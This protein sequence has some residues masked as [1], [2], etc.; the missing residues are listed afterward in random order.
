MKVFC[1]A[2]ILWMTFAVGL[3]ADDAPVVTVI[4]IDAMP[5]FTQDAATLLDQFKADSMKL[6]A[7]A[8][9]FQVLQEIG[10]TNH[11]TLV[12]TWSDSKTYEAH[13][14]AAHTRA[15]RD[16]MQP[17]LGSPFDERTHNERTTK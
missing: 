1:L 10:H 12:E 5:Q 2:G 16:A 17:M 3:K 9:Q 6:D 15:F 4:H 13:N 14:I 7:G 11:F 8:K